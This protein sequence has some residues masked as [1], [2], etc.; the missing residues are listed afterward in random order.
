MVFARKSTQLLSVRTGKLSALFICSFFSLT[1][2]TNQPSKDV[3][4][5]LAQSAEFHLTPIKGSRLIPAHYIH[6]GCL[7]P[8]YGLS[9]AGFSFGTARSDL[10]R[11]IFSTSI[12]SCTHALL[13]YFLRCICCRFGHSRTT[14]E[15]I[16][17]ISPLDISAVCQPGNGCCIAAK[18]G[19]QSRTWNI[20][21]TY[22]TAAQVL[23]CR[24]NVTRPRPMF[25]P[26]GDRKPDI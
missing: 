1:H 18:T 10:E 13:S 22:A 12:R 20:D 6:P 16:S 3:V 7:P 15:T 25:R 26:C 4:R 8:Q 9:F 23:K 2:P 24:N 5:S 11:R 19:F 17:T 14:L 21:L